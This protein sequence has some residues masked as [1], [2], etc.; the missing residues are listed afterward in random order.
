MVSTTC[1]CQLCLLVQASKLPTC[2]PASCCSPR[3]H[4]LSW[5][6]GMS[7]PLPHLKLCPSLILSLDHLYPVLHSLWGSFPKSPQFNSLLKPVSS[8]GP[9]RPFPLVKPCELLGTWPL[10]FYSPNNF[11]LSYNPVCVSEFFGAM[12]LDLFP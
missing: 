11:K 6:A 5:G 8:N 9:Q 10:A 2:K 4:L 1:V 7:S 12:T 3:G